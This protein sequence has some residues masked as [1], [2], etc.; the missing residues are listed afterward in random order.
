MLT[1]HFAKVILIPLFV[2]N[3]AAMVITLR[4][5]KSIRPEFSANL[6]KLFLMENIIG[7]VCC[8]A[9]AYISFFVRH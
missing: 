5:K 9:L 1:L 4:I 7:L 8:L 3:M 2:L 6:N